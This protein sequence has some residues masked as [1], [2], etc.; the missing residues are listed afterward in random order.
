MPYSTT[1]QR[2]AT[3]ADGGAR[4]SVVRWRTAEASGH[5]NQGECAGERDS[6]ESRDSRGTRYGRIG[7]IHLQTSKMHSQRNTNKAAFCCTT[8]RPY[9][10]VR[11][12]D[13]TGTTY[14]V[15]K[16]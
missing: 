9:V 6:G 13:S 12:H 16:I 4:E 3:G 5:R 7:G 15:W 8:S 1:N 11:L 14:Q 2:A 10:L